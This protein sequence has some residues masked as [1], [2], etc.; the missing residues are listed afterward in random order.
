MLGIYY[1]SRDAQTKSLDQK[2]S[3]FFLLLALDVFKER[4]RKFGETE[5]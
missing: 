2:K 1:A 3:S 4:K 5:K